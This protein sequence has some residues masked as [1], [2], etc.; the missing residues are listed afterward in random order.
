MK[1]KY[2]RFSDLLTESAGEIVAKKIGQF[3]ESLMSHCGPWQDDSEALL[4]S[5]FDRQVTWPDLWIRCVSLPSHEP[6]MI[7]TKMS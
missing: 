2:S 5:E 3:R 6:A 7:S 4:R 1:C